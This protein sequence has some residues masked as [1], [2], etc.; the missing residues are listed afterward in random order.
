M[1][2]VLV[3]MEEQMAA[4]GK[5]S[6][7]GR[8][9]G[10]EAV[11]KSLELEFADYARLEQAAQVGQGRHL[12]ARPGLLGDACASDDLSFFDDQDIQTRPG[13]ISGSD[14][15]VMPGPYDYCV[16][17]NCRHFRSLERWHVGTFARSHT[18]EHPDVGISNRHV[19]Q[20][21]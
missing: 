17:F 7:E 4:V 2:L 1:S 6:E 13:Q 3:L 11:S 8:V 18:L 15:T 16:V 9:F 12:V 21:L 20:P 19:E 5:H 14:Q 10:I